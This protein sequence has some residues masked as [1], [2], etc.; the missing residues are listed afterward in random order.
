MTTPTDHRETG[1][2]G[3]APL[4]SIVVPTYRRAALLRRSL[5]A[6]QAQTMPD[7]EVLVCDNGADSETRA[8]VDDLDD[9]RFH[10]LPRERNLGI[11]R[12]A[13]AGFQAARAALV[14]EVDDDDILLPRCLE[15]LVR[16]FRDHPDIVLSSGRIQRIY[17]ATANLAMDQAG[18]QPHEDPSPASGAEPAAAP[19][20]G[21]DLPLGKLSPFTRAAASGATPLISTMIRKDAVDW[22]AVPDSVATSY[23]LHVVLAAARGASAAF[24][25]PEMVA[26]YRLHE[27]ADGVVHRIDQLRGAVAT[28]EQEIR[29]GGHHD[30]DLLHGHATRYRLMLTRALLR[31]GD[32]ADARRAFAP[33]CSSPRQLDKEALLLLALLLLPASLARRIAL[34]REQR[35]LQNATAAR[36]PAVPHTSSAAPPDAWPEMPGAKGSGK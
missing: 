23:D 27:E 32:A 13:M 4:V 29:S 2:G 20:T 16:P 18:G 8:V 6:I 24:Y 33:M 17:T 30:V 11:L 28:Y 3:T 31:Q 15:V 21:T 10:Y 36:K 26:V 5:A 35:Y 14:M 19:A 25:S 1:P 22:S 34:A 7:F 9:S 12:N